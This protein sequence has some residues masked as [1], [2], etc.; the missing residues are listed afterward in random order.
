M[1]LK[2]AADLKQMTY[3]KDVKCQRSLHIS[4][5]LQVLNN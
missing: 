1:S 5:F 4:L 3:N 2:Y